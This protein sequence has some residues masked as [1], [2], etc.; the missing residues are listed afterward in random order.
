MGDDEYKGP[1]EQVPES[2]VEKPP[3]EPGPQRP[4]TYQFEDWALI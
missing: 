3:R 2:S 1:Q 4:D